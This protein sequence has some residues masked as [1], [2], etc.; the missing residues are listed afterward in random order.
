MIVAPERFAV[1]AGW[2]KVDGLGRQDGVLASDGSGAARV[3]INLPQGSWRMVVDILPTYAGADG[4]PL[5]LVVAVDG[6]RQ[7][8]DI[9]R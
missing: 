3:R 9:P 4:G 6:R 2:R 1:S 5:R 8:I 7:R